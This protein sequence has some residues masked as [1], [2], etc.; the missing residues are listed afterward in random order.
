MQ[1]SYRFHRHTPIRYW[2]LLA[3][4][5][6]VVLPGA[7]LMIQPAANALASPGAAQAENEESAAIDAAEQRMFSGPLHEDVNDPRVALRRIDVMLGGSELRVAF[8]Q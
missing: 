4:A 8:V 5:S 2:L 6:L 1:R 7:A 3:A